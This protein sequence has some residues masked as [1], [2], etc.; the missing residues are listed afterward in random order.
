MSDPLG[1]QR[2]SHGWGSQAKALLGRR[3]LGYNPNMRRNWPGNMWQSVPGR[4]NS[5]YKLLLIVTG[6]IL[7]CS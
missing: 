2:C 6:G 5:R 3:P 4:G 7:M 1:R